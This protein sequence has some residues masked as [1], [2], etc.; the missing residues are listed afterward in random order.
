MS[1]RRR[2]RR[3]KRSRSQVGYPSPAERERI[4]RQRD[5]L[6]KELASAFAPDR[7]QERDRRLAQLAHRYGPQNLKIVLD[8]MATSTAGRD[9]I[10]EQAFLYR[11]YRRA[12]AR[13]GGDRPFLDKQEYER[14]VFEF[15]LLYGKR[16]LLS[17]RP[18][19]PSPRERELFDLLL[20][21]ADYWQDIT[22]PAVPPRPGDYRVPS[23]GQY[24][25]PVHELLAWG[26]DLE[27]HVSEYGRDEGKWRSAI[28][29]LVGMTLNKGWLNGWPGETSSW[30]PYHALHMLGHLGAHQDAGHLLALLNLPNDWLSDRLPSVWAQMGPPVEPLL[31]EYV[32]D[33]VNDAQKRSVALM[34]LELISQLHPARRSDV[35]A[36]LARRL[37]LSSAKDAKMNGYVVFILDRMQATEAG[38]TIRDAFEQDKVDR[39]TVTL[40]D[41][42]WL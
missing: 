13:F 32:G 42:T 26:W 31:W 7:R 33:R 14:L 5:A 30:A 23:P 11:S 27:R 20:S 8:V 41:V 6:I 39:K 29:D 12:F 36:G 34:G 38:E 2:P 22:P 4:I 16:A 17:A 24:G 37:Q 28:P 18:P 1:K 10:G 35:V 40:D 21:Q 3:R 25:D 9:F 15:A 19:P